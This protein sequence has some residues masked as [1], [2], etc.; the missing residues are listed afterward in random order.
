MSNRRTTEALE[1]IRC[2]ESKA[3]SYGDDRGAAAVL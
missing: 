3:G 2:P 1:A